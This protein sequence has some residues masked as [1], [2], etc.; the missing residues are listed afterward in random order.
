MAAGGDST[1]TDRGET[2]VELVVALG[3]MSVA[4]VAIVGGVGTSIL[5][6]DVHR[7]QATAGAYLRDYAEAIEKDVAASPSAYTATPSCTPSYASGFPVPSGYTAQITAASFWNGSTF[8]TPCNAAADIG[9][10]RISLRVA[11]SDGRATETLDIIVRRP[12]RSLDTPC[13]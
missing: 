7:K 4:V 12:C 3:I 2:L 10:Q 9:V 1:A 5:M 6:S 13:A 8:L 11:S